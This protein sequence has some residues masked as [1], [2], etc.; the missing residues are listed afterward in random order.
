MAQ[1]EIGESL[2]TRVLTYAAFGNIKQ[3]DAVMKTICDK[4]NSDLVNQSLL[5]A[6]KFGQEDLIK[7]LLSNDAYKK[8][9][10][11]NIS[12]DM[13]QTVLHFAAASAN[14]NII[15]MMIDFS[16]HNKINLNMNQQDKEGKTPLHW[17]SSHNHE[18][19]VILLIKN[20]ANINIKDK[21][22]NPAILTTMEKE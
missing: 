10:D 12:N 9:I 20:G 7:H 19:T 2:Q 15:L 5:E 11:I 16:K 3:F 1:E 21:L 13:N 14:D 8:M 6:S 17:A 4:D 22:G 18:S